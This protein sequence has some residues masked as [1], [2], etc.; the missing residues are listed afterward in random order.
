MT[1][2]PLSNLASKMTKTF[3]ILALFGACAVAPA[4]LA[5]N[6]D[7][8]P[9][10]AVVQ[11]TAF[12]EMTTGEAVY[13]GICQG[14]HMADAKGAVGAGAYP[15]LASNDRLG[16]AAYPLMVVIGGQKAMPSFGGIL[17]DQQ[18]SDVVSYVR[19]NFGN[20]YRDKVVPKDVAD[21]RAT[22]HP[23]DD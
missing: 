9:M 13:K 20:R 17:N 8:T 6:A 19:T 18:I 12:P 15:A 11:R 7:P 23:K 5:Q 22:V 21:M 14:C 4:A 2:A 1:H 10:A 16:T 3:A